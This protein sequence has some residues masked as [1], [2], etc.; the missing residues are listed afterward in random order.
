[1]P[2]RALVSGIPRQAARVSGRSRR[3]MAVAIAG[4]AVFVLAALAWGSSERFEWRMWFALAGAD[5]TPAQT[6]APVTREAVL[7]LPRRG[8]MSLARARALAT[9]G[10]LHDALIALDSIHSTDPQKADADRL[11][12]DIQ[13]QLLALTDLPDSGLADREKGDRRIP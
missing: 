13:R 8:E 7:P 1:M 9:E 12:T 10:R 4:L 5:E 3:T 11:R 2:A 6:A